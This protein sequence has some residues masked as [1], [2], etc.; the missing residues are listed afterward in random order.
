M[1]VVAFAVKQPRYPSAG[2]LTSEVMVKVCPRLRLH[3]R[4]PPTATESNSPGKIVDFS[5]LD[6]VGNIWDNASSQ[7]NRISEK[8]LVVFICFDGKILNMVYCINTV[9]LGGRLT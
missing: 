4:L 8:G 5:A 7:L 3:C 1:G 2:T 9:Y 6:V